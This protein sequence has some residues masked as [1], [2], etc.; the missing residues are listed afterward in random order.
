CESD[1]SIDL[2]NVDHVYD[3][4]EPFEYFALRGIS[5]HIDEGAF[6][7]IVGRT[8]SGKST[9]VEH[10][11]GLLFSARGDVIVDDE[12]V[13]NDRKVLAKVR[14]RVGIVFQYPEDQFFAE[15]IFEEVA[16]GC[17]NYGFS[18]EQVDESVHRAMKTVG[19]DPERFLS[20]SPFQ[21][22][23]GEQRRVAIASIIAMGQ[24]YIVLDEPTAGLDSGSKLAVLAELESLRQTTHVTVIL[25]SHNMDEVAEFCK[26]V[27][28]LDN[29]TVAFQ[30][31]TDTF[32][33]NAALVDR[34]GLE[35]PESYRLA[36]ALKACGSI[37]T[38]NEASTER[39]LESLK[40]SVSDLGG[41]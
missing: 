36:R 37:L 7:G 8:G 31:S 40:L 33:S 1:M 30:G 15:T 6:V 21:L 28:V 13:S 9:L 16:F 35:L 25:V 32:F 14:R 10:L 27:I 41:A 20:L 38:V 24:K 5:L 26:Q 18:K 12:V 19:L 29:G 22:S 17:R 11:N 2:K 23:G 4:G 34:T 3:R 39:M